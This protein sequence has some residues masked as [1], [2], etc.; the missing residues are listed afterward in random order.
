MNAIGVSIWEKGLAVCNATKRGDGSY[1]FELEYVKVQ[2][3]TDAGDVAAALSGSRLASG[4]NS[5][6]R[7]GVS[8]K[9]YDVFT[10]C[11]Q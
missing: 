7:G 2:K 8:C 11:H 9:R 10:R 3:V 5:L 6:V 4:V 1:P